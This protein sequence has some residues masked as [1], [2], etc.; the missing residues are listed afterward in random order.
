M[1]RDRHQID[2]L[3]EV[4]GNI[5][6]QL[7]TKAMLILA[8]FSS[9]AEIQPVGLGLPGVSPGASIL[10]PEYI[11]GNRRG[12]QKGTCASP[13]RDTRPLSKVQTAIFYL[14]LSL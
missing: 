7:H 6:F 1:P 13:C 2:G 14:F 9:E 10:G 11:A 5:I 4:L 8:T 12:Q 3:E